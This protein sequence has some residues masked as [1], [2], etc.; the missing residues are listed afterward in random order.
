MRL[1]ADILNK[2]GRYIFT[3][4]HDTGKYNI[5]HGDKAFVV[6]SDVLFYRYILGRAGESDV[7]IFFLPYLAG[8]NFSVLCHSL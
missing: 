3:Q 7:L 8:Y 4:Q 5:A 2:K 6:P 1:G